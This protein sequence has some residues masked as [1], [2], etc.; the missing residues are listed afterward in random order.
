MNAAKERKARDRIMKNIYQLVMQKTEKHQ[1]ATS[2]RETLSL[3]AA[4]AIAAGT[5]C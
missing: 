1:V 5:G 3:V 2:L 4:C